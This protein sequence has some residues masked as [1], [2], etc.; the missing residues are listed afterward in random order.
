MKLAGVVAVIDNITRHDQL[1]FVIDGDLDVVAR[2]D[3]TVLRQQPGIRIGSRQ[4]CLAALLQLR[5]IGL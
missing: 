5:Q 2:H 1:V 4:L 3:L